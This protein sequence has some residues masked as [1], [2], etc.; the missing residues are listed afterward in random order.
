MELLKAICNQKFSYPL[1]F[2]PS[3]HPLI[4]ALHPPT[5][6]NTQLYGLCTPA[7]PTPSGQ[8]PLPVLSPRDR[9][10]EH[11]NEP[12]VRIRHGGNI[13][14]SEIFRTNNAFFLFFRIPTNNFIIPPNYPECFGN[15]LKNNDCAH[16]YFKGITHNQAFKTI[17]LNIFSIVSQ[18]SR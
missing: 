15:W 18:N 11:R 1:I 9:E 8:G 14:K 12:Q 5:R 10:Q 7:F 16:F 3:P 2:F 6:D 13:W 17:K 4:P